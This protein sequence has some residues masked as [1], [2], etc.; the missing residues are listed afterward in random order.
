M[1]E[2]P[3]FELTAPYLELQAEARTLAAACADIAA[4]A[5]EADRFDPDVRERLAASGLVDVVVAARYGG[6]EFVV[7]LPGCSAADASRVADRIRGEIARRAHEVPVTVSAGAATMPD[8]AVDAER[9]VAAADGALYDAKRAG[10]DR[11]AAS[12]RQGSGGRIERVRWRA[13]IARGA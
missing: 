1:T 7:L 2:G 5:D 11:T 6:D 12:S 10:R 13:A 8:N 9:L 4:R 3:S